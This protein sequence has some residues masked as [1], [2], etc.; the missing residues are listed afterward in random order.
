MT[1]EYRLVVERPEHQQGRRLTTYPKQS[2]THAQRALKD[3]QVH[4][5]RIRHVS[6]MWE[7]WIETREVSKWTKV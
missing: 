2:L 3:H 7:A 6:Q 5:E 1:K 4:A